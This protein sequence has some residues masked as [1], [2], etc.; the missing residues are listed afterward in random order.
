MFATAPLGISRLNQTP[1]RSPG[2][3]DDTLKP[4]AAVIPVFQITPIGAVLSFVIAW[5]APVE[6]TPPGSNPTAIPGTAWIVS[7][8][9]PAFAV[10]PRRALPV[11]GIVSV[12]VFRS[13]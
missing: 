4:V 7:V 6:S 5:I 3:T 1:I 9:A 2:S 13:E 10:V 12:S 11:A 8:A